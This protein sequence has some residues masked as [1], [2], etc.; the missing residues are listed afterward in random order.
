MLLLRANPS[1]AMLAPLCPSRCFLSLKQPFVLPFSHTHTT[2][3]SLIFKS[4]TVLYSQSHFARLYLTVEVLPTPTI[5][6]ICLPTDNVIRT[7]IVF[8]RSRSVS[9]LLWEESRLVLLLLVTACTFIVYTISRQQECVA[10]RM[11]ARRRAQAS[12]AEPSPAGRGKG[13]LIKGNGK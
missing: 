7:G 2:H 8:T 1:S 9:H 12:A 5:P 3:H 4:L 6:S 11:I 10:M 13:M